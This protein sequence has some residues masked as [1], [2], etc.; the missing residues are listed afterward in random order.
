M[1]RSGRVAWSGEAVKPQ[2]VN[3]G[4]LEAIPE[5]RSGFFTR[6]GGVS[7][8]IYQ[9]LNTGVGSRDD[10]AFVFKNRARAARTLG[11][12]YDRLA[13]PYQVHSAKAA[14][15]TEPWE[16]GQG[17]KVDALVTDRPGIA[18][19]VGTADCGPVLFADPNAQVIGAAHAGWR[20]ALGGVLEATIE[21][22]T[23]LGA[24]IETT[25]AVLG[26][27]ISQANYE[28]GEDLI[29]AF[30]EADQDNRRFF[31]PSD[32]PGH[33]LFDLPGYITHRLFRAGVLAADVGLCTYADE[34]RFFSYRR[35]THRGEADYGR[36]LA[37][38]TLQT[39]A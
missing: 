17:P 37:A 28:V 27:T 39:R 26:P 24:E 31:K 5:I 11:L 6:E 2:P 30:D 3:H 25:V 21:A 38:I 32:R 19:G 16:A 36:M 8:G 20:G 7:A 35:A 22:M 34:A 13:T 4:L 23:A 10:R 29:R 15:V 12:T 33:A 14:T 1:L 9:S 18:I